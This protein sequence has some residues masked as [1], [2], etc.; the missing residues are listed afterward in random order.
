M[1]PYFPILLLLG[2]CSAPPDNQAST[3][4]ERVSARPEAH[5]ERLARVLGCIGCHGDDLTGQNWSD[6]LGVLWTSN[7]TRS[8]Q[9]WTAEEFKEALVTG[10]QPG[11]RDL[12]D[13]PSYLFTQLTEEEL[14]AITAYVRS[15][16]AKGPIHPD[17][18]M[19]PVL[20][21]KQKEGVYRSS[22][23]EV[24]ATG[25]STAPV[26]PGH[27]LARH[28]TRATCAECHGIDLRGKTSPID[29][30]S[31]PDI[32]PLAA[33]YSP[34]DFETFMTTG[35]AAG[36]RELPLMSKVARNRFSHLTKAE[37]A[38][39]HAYLKALAQQS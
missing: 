22:A 6:D 10:H 19:G 33:S 18:S 34:E 38:A 30:K 7:L 17:P 20:Q 35:K 16:P 9:K 5:G 21:A 14:N 8:G 25:A 27:E 39:I 28:I 2:S 26:A 1:R 31:T 37:R 13:M 12:W 36:G 4:F 15:R 24:R 29:G 32:R 3:A 11:G 23:A